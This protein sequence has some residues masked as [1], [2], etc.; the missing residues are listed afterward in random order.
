MQWGQDGN[1]FMVYVEK[2]EKIMDAITQFCV[3]KQINNGFISGIGAIKSVEI[4]AFDINTKNYIRKHLEGPLELTSFQ[5]NITIKDGKPFVHAHVTVGDHEMNIMGG[6]LF[7]ATV[8][9]VGEFSLEQRTY[10]AK[11][12]L[13]ED[14][15][16]PCICLPET[17]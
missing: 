15:G 10:N 7:E 9:A 11:R 12:I 14:V 4:G 1:R 17:F 3:E 6:H 16:L 5:G 13:N 8:A 2:N